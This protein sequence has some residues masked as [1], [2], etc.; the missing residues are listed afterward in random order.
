MAALT[1]ALP[2][3][4]EVA[5]VAALAVRVGVFPRARHQLP[6]DDRVRLAPAFEAYAQAQTASASP[7]TAFMRR[8]ASL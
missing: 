8:F 6:V 4:V 3:G 7:S 2:A 1:A 5:V